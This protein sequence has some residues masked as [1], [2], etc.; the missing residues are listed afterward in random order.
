MQQEPT[1]DSLGKFVLTSVTLGRHELQ[2][3]LVGY[4]PVVLKEIQVTSSKEVYLDVLMKEDVK[5]LDDVVVTAHVNKQQPLNK[6]ATLSARML[7]VEEASRYAGGFDDPARL[8]TAFAGVAGGM[9]SNSIA[10]RGNSPQF[11]Q[12]RLEGM[13]MPNP[14]HFSEMTGVGGGVLTALSSNVLG[15]SDFFTGA[16]P[17]EYGNALSGVFDMQMHNGNKW[18]YEHSVQVGTIGF[19]V[20]SEGPLGKEGTASYLFNYRYGAMA[21]VGKLIPALTGEIG[22]MRYQ[23]LSFKVDMPTKHAGTFSLWGIGILDNY[24]RTMPLWEIPNSDGSSDFLQNKAVVGIRHK[25]FL[26]DKTYIDSSLGFNYTENHGKT[27]IAASDATTLPEKVLDMWGINKNLT[28]NSY[29]NKKLSAAHTNRT[30]ISMTELFYNLDYNLSPSLNTAPVLPIVNFAKSNGKA[31]KLSLFSSSTLWLSHAWTANIGLHSLYFGL[32]N[33][34]A[35]EPRV[36]FKWQASPEHAF[37]IAYG[38]HSRHE[39]LDYYFVQLEDKLV[40]QA[41]KLAK[42]HHFG[43][44]YDWAISNNR[45]LKIEPYF[46]YM[47]DVPVVKDSMYSIINQKDFYLNLP[48]INQGEGKNYGID[49]TLERYLHDGYYYMVTASVFE[50]LYKGGDKVW[51]NTRM[52]RQFLINVLGGKEWYL[53]R[54]NQNVLSANIRCSFQGG[55]RYIP[56]DEAATAVANKV[57]Y[58]V[59]HAYETQLPNAFISN[60]TVSYKMNRKNLAHEFAVKI[61]NANGYSEFEGYAY[62][63]ESDLPK[64]YMMTVIMPNVSYK[65]EF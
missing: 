29:V 21:L 48:L 27:H 6:M 1:T 12:W 60:V 26:N 51:R 52:N 9:S 32:N 40:N 45:H 47:Y 44:A 16:F 11:L 64:K 38:K 2:I 56:A 17:A 34:W 3:S 55:D 15:N 10:I 24:K 22:G 53:G 8:V 58:D 18:S 14:T 43:L 13:E 30:G 42:A 25:I 62:D 39:K 37:G 31:T 57:I 19:D 4:H 54:N 23:D 63:S 35:I 59:T 33:E 61:I 65:I 5:Q 50:S 28:L 41:L 20:A 36:G 46:Q 7:S 49:F